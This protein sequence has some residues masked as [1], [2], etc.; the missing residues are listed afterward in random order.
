MQGEDFFLGGEIHGHAFRVHGHRRGFVVRFLVD[1]HAVDDVVHAFVDVDFQV[2]EFGN[3]LAFIEKPLRVDGCGFDEQLGNGLLG[4]RCDVYVNPVAKAGKGDADGDGGGAQTPQAHAG[5][6]HGG[7]FVVRGQTAVHQ[8]NGRQEPPRNGEHQR[9][10]DDLEDEF[11]NDADG[12]LVFHQEGTQFLEQVAQ[13]EQG[14]QGHYPQ[15][16]DTQQLAG[17]VSVKD[18]HAVKPCRILCPK[19][20]DKSISRTEQCAS[21]PGGRTC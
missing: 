3:G 20:A 10:G 2:V 14:A 6:A 8:K 19:A 13:K 12:S 18:L 9:K 7:E 1:M 4:A 11:Q 15:G 17:N 5:H 21:R 16:R